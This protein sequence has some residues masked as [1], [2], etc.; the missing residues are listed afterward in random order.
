LRY[1]EL[2]NNP[3]SNILTLDKLRENTTIFWFD[4]SQAGPKIE[5]PWLWVI[6]TVDH[7]SVDDAFGRDFLAEMSEGDVT[8]LEVATNGARNGDSVGDSVWTA[9]RISPTG[10]NNINDMFGRRAFRVD[11]NGLV[12]GT[13]DGIAY[14]S[15]IFYSPH[16]QQTMM[17]SGSNDAAKIWLNG[18]LVHKKRVSRW[19]ENYETVFPVTLK[20]GTNVLLVAVYQS[21]GNWSGFFGF[22][23]DAEYMV[24]TPSVGYTFSKP[25]IHVGETFILDISAQKIIDLAGWQFDIAFDPDRLEA[26]EVNEGDFLKNSGGTTFFQKGTIDNATGNITKLSSARLN[27]DG[28]TGTGTLLSVTFTAKAGGETQI[29]LENFQFGSITG[30][31][32][33]AGPHE[34]AF[35]IEGQLATGDVNRDGQVSVLDLILVAQHLGKDASANPQAD[36]N[37]DGTINIQ[38]LILVAQHL[39]ESTDAAAPSVI[40]AMNNGEL[41]P[42]M[43]QAWITQAQ[44]ENDGSLAFRQGI[45]TLERLLALFIPDETA[46]LHS[47]PNPFNPETWIPYQLAEP[48]EVTLTI[49]SVNGTL[50]RT[51]ALGH[52]PA[53]IYQTRT[54]AAYW[55]G[56][57]EVGESVA[58]GVYFYTLTANDFSA[59]RKMLIRK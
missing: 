32:I 58:S 46:L 55:D 34:F 53:G 9:H 41:T 23:L 31:I 16:E 28:V 48:A 27:E 3:I 51:L 13:A 6:H 49:H 54:H 25:A 24:A 40:A 4:P 10:D 30:E 26:I 29:M 15:I 5:G 33:N 36:V 8:E 22:A 1:L 44:I 21:Q 11:A 45:A 52:Q 59:T 7:L 35:T 42:T 57:N 39:G 12:T 47:Y 38:D 43:V 56:K 14:G 20:Q 18:Q 2:Q 19:A 17:F 37:Q 50:V